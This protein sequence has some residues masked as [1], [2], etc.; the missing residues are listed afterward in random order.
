MTVSRRS[1]VL[2][3]AA[4]AALGAAML[5]ALVTGSERES[6]FYAVAE[7]VTGESFIAAG[8]VVSARRPSNRAGLLMVAVGFAWL[9]R[10]IRY[11]ETSWTF[12]LGMFFEGLQWL[13]LAHLMVT[14]PTGRT[15]D[16]L[17]RFTV[18]F[19]YVYAVPNA[20]GTLPFDEARDCPDC[21]ANLLS[22]DPNPGA[23]AAVRTG[24]VIC[25]IIIALLGL[26]CFL[27]RWQRATPSGRRMFTPVFAGA[28]IAFGV[29]MVGLVTVAALEELPSGVMQLAF[30]SL[31]TGLLV[32]LL[33]GWLDRQALSQLMLELGRASTPHRLRGLLARALHDPTL[34]LLYWDDR[35][36]AYLDMEG[37]RR[38]PPTRFAQ[39]AVTRLG[40]EDRPV[41][42]L[43]H[44]PL[45][46]DDPV[47]VHA[48]GE[49]ARFALDNE[50]LQ[51]E[52]RAQ[53][54]EVRAS[55]A[56]IV[57]AAD[58]ERRRVERDLHDGAQQRLVT[59]SLELGLARAHAASGGDEALTSSLTEVSEEVARALNELRELGRGLHPTI[60]AEAGLGP[61]LESLAERS[62]VPATVAAA[63]KGRL[64]EAVE[65][66]AY[67]VA[68]EALANV[69]K[70]ADASHVTLSAHPN[71]G[72]LVLEVADDGCGGADPA[73]GS[74]LTGLEDRVAAL[75]G[76]L[77]VESPSG[78][79]TR[80]VAE[81]PC[82]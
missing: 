41:G 3:G 80:I 46:L 44:D 82:A 24:L 2:V 17:E 15:Q 43:L 20:F 70:H 12:T 36:R 69:A 56:R 25:S 54:E 8:L 21:L 45:L 26:A 60:L 66:G 30:L 38:E 74:G 10:D 59:L 27:R 64:P 53:L 62:S 33:R 52:V 28:L 57:D 55:R 61:A 6:G 73:C 13:I 9:I 7:V 78:A 5:A 76:Q 32:G 49:A 16:R 71:N 48:V 79:G 42:A 51:A 75:G 11:V 81:I 77:S 63:P 4:G 1:R 31:S 68:S 58:A 37:R 23:A 35:Q 65:I 22:I 40:P 29:A 14:Y 18:G 19:I 34:E 50:R 67:F 72:V 47:L 39:R